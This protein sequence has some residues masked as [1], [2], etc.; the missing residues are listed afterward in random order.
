MSKKILSVVLA[1]ALA[2]SCFAVGVSAVGGL[3]YES[4][5]DAA[6]Y[7][8]TWALDEPVQNG[9]TYTVNVR[10]TANYSVGI[11]EFTVNKVVSSGSL[12]LT[13]VVAGEAIP[14]NWCETVA[15]SDAKNKVMIVP[16]PEDDAIPG[17]DNPNNAI[18]AVLTYTASDDVNASLAIDVA[19]VKSKTN[20]A[21]T[22]FAARMSDGN[23]VTGTPIVGQTV[24]PTNTVTIGS[25]ATTPPTLV[26][27][28]DT[29]GV[30][31]TSRTMLDEQDTDGD[32]DL[33]V[34]DG[35]LLGFD[36]DNNGS[37]TELFTVEG[38]G[39]MQIV[40]T[41]AGSEAATGTIVNVVDL[42]SNVVATYV[43]IVFGDVNGD[44][45]ADGT[46]ASI[47]VEHDA[48]ML[49]DWG[50]LYS[51]QEF[52]GDTNVDYGCDGTDASIIVEHD[53]WML[54]DLGRI[55][56]AGIIATLGF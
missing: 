17:I 6:Y 18:I 24:N 39:E 51:F 20:P 45:F 46:D 29:L 43:V 48:W 35:Y 38:D 52:A 40:A 7:Q 16:N 31:D 41:E 11:I 3:G 55:D 2:L 53:A 21:G 22:T 28:A 1:L 15:F 12:I 49:G 42:E 34:I 44:G 50:R 8:Q 27:I 30:V 14:A 19:N 56:V 5:E 9:N 36:P 25:A 32:G 33:Q 37:I 26:A 4:D 23:V 10:L 47:I 13:N 54:G